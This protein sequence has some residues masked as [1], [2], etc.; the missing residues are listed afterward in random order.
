MEQADIKPT[1]DAPVSGAKLEALLT[2][3]TRVLHEETEITRANRFESA[4]DVLMRKERCFYELTIAMLQPG[5]KQT[6]AERPEILNHLRQAITENAAVLA[7]KA[8]AVKGVVDLLAEAAREEESD[9][10]YGHA[11]GTV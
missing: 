5:A 2:R 11:Y 10:T 3:T 9:G 7:S 8:S 4:K 1:L 6:L